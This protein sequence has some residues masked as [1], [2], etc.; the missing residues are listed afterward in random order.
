MSITQPV[1]CQKLDQRAVG[2]LGGISRLAEVVDALQRAAAV[3]TLDPQE[4]AGAFDQAAHRMDRAFVEGQAG[5]LRG[6]GLGEAQPLLA[7]VVLVLEEVLGQEHPQAGAEGSG[8]QHEGEDE[9]G[10]EQEG[11]LQQCPQ[12]AAHVPQVVAG[13][14]HGHQVQP[15]AG[16][17]CGVEQQPSG[18]DRAV[19]VRRPA[20]DRHR[21]QR[22]H[23]GVDEASGLPGRALQHPEQDQVGKQEQVERE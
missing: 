5:I 9:R 2:G 19:P 3:V 10:T 11:D 13:G 4:A 1:R 23:E 12:F 8:E 18:D 20:G 7:V 17:G 16:Q 21:D 22:Y 6:Q 14:P 15:R